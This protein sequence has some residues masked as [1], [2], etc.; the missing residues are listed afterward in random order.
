[1]SYLA[2]ILNR[3]KQADVSIF[4]EKMQVMEKIRKDQ[5]EEQGFLNISMVADAV[6]EKVLRDLGIEKEKPDPTPIIETDSTTEMFS[7]F[8][9]SIK[10]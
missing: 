8:L 9:Q 4:S 10:G 7:K 5:L 6:Q 1:M 3:V 2:E